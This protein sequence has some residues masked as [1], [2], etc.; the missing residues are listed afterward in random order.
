MRRVLDRRRISVARSRRRRL[1]DV[2]HYIEAHAFDALNLRQLS[3]RASMSPFHFL[4]EYARATGETPIATMR[5]VRLLHARTLLQRQP[6]TQIEEIAERCGYSGSVAFGRAFRKQ[7]GL[8][9]GQLRRMPPSPSCTARYD[10][11]RWVEIPARS[12]SCCIEESLGDAPFDELICLAEGMGWETDHCAVIGRF[13]P[14]SSSSVHRIDASFCGKPLM[15]MSLLER[16][17]IDPGLCLRVTGTID[18][19]MRFA[20]QDLAEAM[21]RE[22]VL[23]RDEDVF[24]HYRTDPSYSIGVDR[25]VDVLF[26]VAPRRVGASAKV[27]RAPV[28]TPW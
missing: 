13:G 7:F 15:H 9:L 11:V 17:V 6:S 20:A 21:E 25:V 26:P 18:E 3:E 12:V 27:R 8:T 1:R 19:A 22:G 5:R 4:R 24:V 23:R 16:G 28:L 14:T 10:L 2:V